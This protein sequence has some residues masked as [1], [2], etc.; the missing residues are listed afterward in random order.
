MLFTDPETM[1]DT[2]SEVL[3][4]YDF[5]YPLTY[6]DFRRNEVMKPKYHKIFPPESYDYSVWIDGTITVKDISHLAKN[7]KRVLGKNDIALFQHPLRDSWLQELQECAE[8]ALD[9]SKYF[10]R[11]LK[12]YTDNIP[13]NGL[14]ECSV[15]I[16]RNTKEM[17]KFNHVWWKEIKKYSTRDQISLPAALYKT[18]TEVSIIP[19]TVQGPDRH[20][21]FTG[22]E[23]FSYTPH[24][25]I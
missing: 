11:Q 8:L 19:G 21:S 17:K 4:S 15:I 9:D 14:Y 20:P 24:N 25:E 1:Q 3:D 13:L 5:I 12:D 16:R 7:V 22:N 2:P 6:E 10:E 18:N 23:F